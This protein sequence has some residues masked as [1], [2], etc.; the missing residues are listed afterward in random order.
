VDAVVVDGM[1]V[2]F[3]RAGHGPPLVLLHG[4]V[5]D[6]A[7]TWQH[8]LDDLADSFTVVAWDAPGAGASSDPPGSYGMSD[9]ADCLAGFV[10]RLELGRPHVAGISF[11]GALALALAQRHPGVPR[12]LVLASAYA[13]WHGSLPPD[14]AAAR[15]RQA[16][17]LSDLDPDELVAALLPSMFSATAPAADVAAFGEAV[18][19]FHP[20]GFRTMARALAGDLRPGLPRIDVPTLVVH[21]AADVRAPREVAE[22][23]HAGIRGSRLAVLPGAGH[24]CCIEAADAFD[25]EVR[26][27]LTS[28][29]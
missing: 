15:L 9:Y 13:G 19:A 17:A 4:Y 2:A 29:G 5:G 18:R 16:V 7:T 24:M 20:A 3:T 11:G 12:S 1:R 23:L 14:V 25:R 22:A 26:A 6:G 8:Q 10:A 27:F 21:G 28:A